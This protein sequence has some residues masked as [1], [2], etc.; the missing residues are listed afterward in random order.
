MAR[1]PA[2]LAG[3]TGRRSLPLA[4]ALGV[5]ALTALAL[6]PALRVVGGHGH[7]RAAQAPV[8]RR[9]GAPR[10]LRGADSRE[11]RRSREMTPMRQ[12][13]LVGVFLALVLVG[14]FASAQETA[15][16]GSPEAPQAPAKLPRLTVSANDT[17]SLDLP[18]GWP[19]LLTV[20]LE[21]PGWGGEAQST[22]VTLAAAGAWSDLLRVEVT[23]E[24]GKATAWP[25]KPAYTPTRSIT[26]SRDVDGQMVW[27]LTA[28]ETAK[29]SPGA[30]TVSVVLEAGQAAA[31]SW[32]GTVRS[33]EASVKIVPQPNPLR[34]ELERRRSLLGIRVALWRGDNKGALAVAEALLAKQPESYQAL[35]AKGEVLTALG[36]PK[37]EAACYEQARSAFRKARPDA[38]SVPFL[39]GDE[40]GSA[41]GA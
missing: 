24:G 1:T 35:A 36:K 10:Q 37:E 34:P 20:C 11:R 12:Q 3:R 4:A 6:R 33:S 18:Q 39:P 14:G 7:Q 19:M 17:T 21:A 30:Y 28:E 27:Y 2:Y 15:A 16:I 32:T 31:G 38:K 29:L 41:P 26:L 5:P 23:D 9:E 13:R 25:L 40:V 8:R 22:P